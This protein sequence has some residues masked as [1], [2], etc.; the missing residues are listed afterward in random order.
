MGLQG[1][2]DGRGELRASR[3]SWIAAEVSGAPLTSRSHCLL[4]PPVPKS[5]IRSACSVC[6]EGSK[7]DC[8]DTRKLHSPGMRKPPPLVG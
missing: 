2:S 6:R 3:A 4:D 1:R 5:A 7:Q 8:E